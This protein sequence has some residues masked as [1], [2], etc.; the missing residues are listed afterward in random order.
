MINGDI[1]Q[2]LDTGWYSEA[3]LYYNGNIYWLE[4]QTTS[5]DGET[6]F[7]V[8]VWAVQNENNEYFHSI[9]ES[10]GSL[11]WT[12]VFE[13]SSLDQD[14]LKRQFLEAPVFEGKTFWQVEKELAWLE[15]S[16]PITSS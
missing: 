15:E 3:T 9:L 7:F 5:K 12:R 16:N 14:W 10:D 8:D 11:K 1:N 4:A 2:F 6:K 13:I